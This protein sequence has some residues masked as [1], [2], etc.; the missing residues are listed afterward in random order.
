MTKLFAFG[1]SLLYT[2]LGYGLITWK[3]QNFSRL[4][5][6]VRKVLV[7]LHVWVVAS[8][9]ALFTGWV[10]SE[11]QTISWHPFPMA[12]LGLGLAG[13]MVILWALSHLRQA[14]LVPSTE[15]PV[16]G[17]PYG[18]VRHPVYAGGILAALGLAYFSGSIR[19]LLYAGVVGVFL[20]WVSKAEEMELFRRYG[21]TYLLYAERT[22]RFVP[23]RKLGYEAKEDA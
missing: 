15:R 5:P 9:I 1:L 16:T 2:G 10:V 4:G 8:N 7:A 12:G 22:G 20:Y 21:R 19:I 18:W 11:Y 3:Y 23:H 6:R 13:A 14:T 17:G